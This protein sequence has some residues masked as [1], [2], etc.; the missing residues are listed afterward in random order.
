MEFLKRG[1]V[2]MLD[3]KKSLIQLLKQNT[4]NNLCNG[5][6]DINCDGIKCQECVFGS[7]QNL[8]ELIEGLQN[9]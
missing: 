5:E 6:S 9:D 8:Q 7:K 1:V 4:V 2:L 3:F